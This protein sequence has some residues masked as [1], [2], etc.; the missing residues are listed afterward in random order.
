MLS[1]HPNDKS[2]RARL[3][4][5]LLTTSVPT[6]QTG[7]RWLDQINGMG[8]HSTGDF[9]PPLITRARLQSVEASDEFN[10]SRTALM[11]ISGSQLLHEIEIQGH[12]LDR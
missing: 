4:R 3:W 6:S 12:A 11:R 10:E 9:G 7:V 2:L 5:T 1:E 8:P